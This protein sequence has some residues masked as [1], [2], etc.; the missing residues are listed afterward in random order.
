MNRPDGIRWRSDKAFGKIKLKV[1]FGNEGLYQK[2]MTKFTIIRAS[3]PYNVILSRSCLITLRAIPSMIHSMM[4][5]PTPKGITTLVTRSV[6]IQSAR[7]I[8]ETF[9]N[10]SRIS[11]KL[12]CSKCSFRM[13]EGKFLGYMV[14][15]EEE[16]KKAFQE[17]KKLIIDLPEGPVLIGPS[18]TE[19][20]C[21][22]R[23]N[24]ESINKEAEY[25]ALLA[26]LRIAKMMKEVL[27]ERSID[28]KEI[29]AIVKEEDGNWMTPIVKCLEEGIWFEDKNCDNSYFL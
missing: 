12:N 17:M 14:T 27:N 1:S 28:K 16:A 13:E 3:S 21:A 6:I 26:G 9:G 25:E 29:N 19:Y 4:K 18:G 22:I 10:L 24:L 2:M 11:M 15:C 7:D 23:L 8:A 5:F 20:T